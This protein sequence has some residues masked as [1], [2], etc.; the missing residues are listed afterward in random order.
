MATRTVEVELKGVPLEVM[1]NHSKAHRGSRNKYGVPEEPDEPEEFL[2]ED[3]C[4]GSI[5]I[6]DI[7]TG[8]TIDDILELV[9]EAA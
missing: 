8:N 2:I 3:V 6:I 5:S 7:L 9:K 4:A 1:F